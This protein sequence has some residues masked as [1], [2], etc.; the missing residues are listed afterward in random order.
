MKFRSRSVGI[1]TSPRARA[2]GVGDF[3][4][5]GRGVCE[6]RTRHTEVN[7]THTEASMSAALFVTLDVAICGAAR[8]QEQPPGDPCVSESIIAY[9]TNPFRL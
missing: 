2:T 9:S 5:V 3:S 4:E 6:S 1:D 7:A 8:A